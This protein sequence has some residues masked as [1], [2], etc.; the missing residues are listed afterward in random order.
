MDINDQLRILSANV[1]NLKT[2]LDR[3][4]GIGLLK[5]GVNSFKA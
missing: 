2:K 1:V 3:S 4:G 5:V